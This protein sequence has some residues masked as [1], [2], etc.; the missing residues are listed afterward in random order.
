M[1]CFR[2]SKSRTCD[3]A[4]LGMSEDFSGEP[5]SLSWILSWSAFSLFFWER[6]VSSHIFSLCQNHLSVMLS[7]GNPKVSEHVIK[8]ISNVPKAASNNKHDCVA[9]GFRRVGCFGVGVSQEL[10]CW[11]GSWLGCSRYR[12]C[13]S[14]W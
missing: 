13:I 7:S 10:T 6:W 4:N 14:D 5:D 1:I 8:R 9:A 3:C 2:I 12:R 11:Q